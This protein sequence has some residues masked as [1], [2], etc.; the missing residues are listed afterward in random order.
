MK[1]KKLI[2]LAAYLIRV[3]RTGVKTELSIDNYGI[4]CTS[5]I[6]SESEVFM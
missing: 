6:F 1:L 2:C 3:K 5:I 4:A